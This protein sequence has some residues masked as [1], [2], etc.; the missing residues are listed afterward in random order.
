MINKYIIIINYN[1]LDFA[2]DSSKG[3]STYGVSLFSYYLQKLYGEKDYLI[4][5]HKIINQLNKVINKE[6]LVECDFSGFQHE[7]LI[8]CDSEFTYLEK[9]GLCTRIKTTDFLGVFISIQKFLNRW[10]GKSLLM[11]IEKYFEKLKNS[12]NNNGRVFDTKIRD[13]DPMS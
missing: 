6:N 7:L 11:E 8:E 1:K 9:W 5:N 3:F 10:D 4:E 12:S 2:I 13:N